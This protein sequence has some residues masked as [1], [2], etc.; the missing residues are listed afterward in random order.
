LQG[1]GDGCFQ[2]TRRTSGHYLGGFLAALVV[3]VILARVWAIS[4]LRLADPIAP[5]LALGNVIGRIGCFSAGCCWGT[6]TDSWIGVRFTEQAHQI[7]G[8]PINVALL[9]TQLFEAG[10]NLVIFVLLLWLRKKRAFYGQIILSYIVL[11]SVERFVI[12][13]W[14]AD[15][16][17]QIM[18]FSSSQFISLCLFPVALLAY[19]WQRR[20]AEPSHVLLAARYDGPLTTVGQISK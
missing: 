19:V 17:E 6:P 5:S 1:I 3:S 9:P 4:W 16:R 12:E 13:F 14:R 2:L 18:N 20:K 7:N 10:A 11:Y 8:T 15:P